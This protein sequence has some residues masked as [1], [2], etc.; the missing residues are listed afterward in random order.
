MKRYPDSLKRSLGIYWRGMAMGAADVVPGVSGGTLALITGIYEELINSLGGLNLRLFTIWRREGFRAF[1]AAGNFA[2]LCSLFAG[3]FTSIIMLAR[4]LT[5]LMATYPVP[6]WAF[7]CGLIVAS[8]WIVLRPVQRYSI[9]VVLMFVLG[10]MAA[11]LIGA[12]PGL[13][14]ALGGG[15]MVFF[16]SGMLAIC[17]MILP[18]IS[19]SFILLLLGMYSPILMAVKQ[20]QLPLLA[21]FVCGCAVGLLLFVHLLKWLLHH[22]HD[23]VMGLLAG[24]MLGSLNTLWPWRIEVAASLAQENVLP[25]MYQQSTGLPAMQGA[26]VVAILAGMMVVVVLAL[27]DKRA[28]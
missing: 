18:G 8:L 20:G 21:A 12:L 1:W 2:F 19:G 7:F 24:F 23:P 16:L 28:Q 10:A 14:S 9:T 11:W 25:Q 3:I 26:A 13:E 5:W 27:S 17:A 22:F 15:A 6:L 4:L